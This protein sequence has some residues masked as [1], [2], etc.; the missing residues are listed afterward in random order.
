MSFAFDLYVDTH[1][2][3][4]GVFQGWARAAV[5]YTPGN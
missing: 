5:V 3:G 2:A 4:D 1:R